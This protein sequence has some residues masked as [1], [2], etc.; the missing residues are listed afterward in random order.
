MTAFEQAFALLKMPV[1]HGTT[2]DA[3]EQIQEEGINPTDHAPQ[4]FEH[5]WHNIQEELGLSDEEMQR[6]IGGDWSFYY[7]D[8][9][10]NQPHSL[11]GKTSAMLNA[12]EWTDQD[13]E[14]GN[15]GVVLEIDDKH[16]DSPFFMPE[17][18]I[19][20]Y[21]FN[22]AKDQRRT[23]KPVPP[24]LIRRVTQEEL[25]AA[26]GRQSEYSPVHN[27]AS[28]WLNEL[29]GGM[30]QNK[31]GGSDEDFHDVLDMRSRLNN[32]IRH[33]NTKSEMNEPYWGLKRKVS[34]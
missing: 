5:Q 10:E 20:G 18:K 19:D 12:L 23:N 24:H 33:A 17:P 3:W 7:G 13:H 30:V 25:D 32:W 1:Y 34:N 27:R 16:P 4:L 26:R 21:G 14:D 22:E 8:Q 29:I 11:G 28:Q 31:Y 9:A 15:H 2:E 6:I